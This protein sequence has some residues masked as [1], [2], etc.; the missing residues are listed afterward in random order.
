MTQRVKKNLAATVVGRGLS[1]ALAFAVTPVYIRLL[2][3]EAYGLFSFYLVLFATAMFLDHAVSS[4]IIRALARPAHS[5]RDRAISADT[6]RTGELISVATGLLIGVVIG[7]SAPWISHTMVH[8]EGLP[9]SEVV[10]AIRLIGAVTAVQWPTM[11]YS[12]ALTGLG[13]LV[14]LSTARGLIAV[15]Q[16]V[17][18]ALVLLLIAP[19][20][21]LLFMWQAACL[22]T[23]AVMLRVMVTR[24][25]PRLAVRAQFSV[26]VI[27]SSWRFGAG[28]MTIAV[29]GTILTQ[30]DKLLVA[31]LLPVATLAAY[32]LAFT[33]ASIISVF[34][35]S[36]V[37]SVAYPL[38]TRLY[39][40]N[41][42]AQLGEE[43]R[44]WTQFIVVLLAPATAVIVIAPMP[45][46]RLWLGQK[47]GMIL[48]IS[49]YLPWV[50]LGTML[51]AIM[52]LP[53]NLQLAAGWTRLSS[54]KNLIAVPI[55]VTVIVYG[56]PRYGAIVSAGAWLVLNL[57]YYLVEVRLMHR[58]LLQRHLANWWIY[59]TA[60]P[61]VGT[62]FSFYII[63]Q[64]I[65]EPS[66]AWFEIT[67]LCAVGLFLTIVLVLALRYPR[68]M[69]Q[70]SVAAAQSRYRRRP[71]D[72][73]RQ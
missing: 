3:P 5:D 7:A 72:E 36:P 49:S 9:P 22:L 52:M 35:V 23:L 10:T 21:E 45:L 57:G 4:T 25:I 30:A 58:Q 24:A 16:W 70:A 41:D 13:R 37:M 11:L 44:R 12:G 56:V 54:I 59:D 47:S 8:A 64:L 29:T 38:F 32:S 71:L 67:K 39:A 48:E 27:A 69:L 62:I 28:A 18:G 51:N 31:K 53:F 19:S 15:A 68:L 2:G 63:D 33:A 17:G 50:A 40:E 73:T 42:M 66:T 60:L 1:G 43:Y 61:I 20:I 26:P 34:I 46:L 55:Y 65:G 6:L 14:D